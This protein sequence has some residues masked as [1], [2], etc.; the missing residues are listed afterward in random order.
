MVEPKVHA[1]ARHLKAALRELEEDLDVD[2]GLVGGLSDDVFEEPQ[3]GKL[4]FRDLGI[5]EKFHFM[6]SWPGADHAVP[7]YRT[8]T[9]VTARKFSDQDG[10][11]TVVAHIRADLMEV[12]RAENATAATGANVPTAE[13]VKP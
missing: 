12:S 13:P 11:R 3:D 8:Y 7:G 1:A 9:K 6:G 10:D 5:G 2:H 4:R